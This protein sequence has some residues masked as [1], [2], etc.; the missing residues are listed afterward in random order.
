MLIAVLRRLFGMT[1]AMSE[2]LAGMAGASAAPTP[3]RAT[4]SMMKLDDIAQTA[5]N[6]LQIV[7]VTLS[8]ARLSTRSISQP[9]G[10]TASA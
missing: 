6:R 7:T 5:V 4:T 9:I 8:S 1:S 2:R 10:S 3:M